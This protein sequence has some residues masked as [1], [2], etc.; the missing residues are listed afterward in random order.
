[1][2]KENIQF[3]KEATGTAH[4]VN[5]E[6]GKWSLLL[7]CDIVTKERK[8]KKHERITNILFVECLNFL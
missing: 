6:N 5:F 1:M 7:F 2:V 3:K 8:K 4:F